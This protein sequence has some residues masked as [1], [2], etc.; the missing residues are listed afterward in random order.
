M[1]PGLIVPPE[2]ILFFIR[3]RCDRLVDAVEEALADPLT[4]GDD[5]TDSPEAREK[6]TRAVNAAKL[7]LA[8]LDEHFEFKNGMAEPKEDVCPD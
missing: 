4:T 2:V 3:V 8:H 7:L 1:T 6:L 5:E